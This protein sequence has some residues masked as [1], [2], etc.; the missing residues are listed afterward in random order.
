VG[1][2][3]TSGMVAFG[4]DTIRLYNLYSEVVEGACASLLQWRTDS[5]F[6]RK[7]KSFF[8]T[9]IIDVI[10]RTLEYFS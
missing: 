5:V 4:S 8:F 10:S 1:S 2:G 3:G 7:E 9:G 6:F